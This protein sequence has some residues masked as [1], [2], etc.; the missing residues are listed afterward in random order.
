M[1]FHGLDPFVTETFSFTDT[2]HDGKC[3]AAFHPFSNKVDHNIISRTDRGGN[4]RRSVLNQYLGISKPYVRTMR[5]SRN[6]YQVGKIFRLGI[7]QHLHGKVCTKLRDPEASQPAAADI[8]RADPQSLRSRKQGHDISL[9]QRNCSCTDAGQILQHTDHGR[10]I[11][12]K[13]IKLQ[14]ISVNGMVI[15][16]CGDDIT[17]HIIGRVLHRCKFLNL[18]THRQ[19]DDTSRM[20]ASGTA[21]TGTTLHDT[22]DLTVTLVLPPF[23]IIVL[24]ITKCGFFRKGTNGSRLKGLP[25][26]E[27]NLC[28]PVGIGLIFTGKVQ[29]DIRLLITFKTKEC[30]KRNIKAF[31]VH[32]GTA[33]RTDLIRHITSCHTR[34][35][36]HLRG[37]KITVFTV[38]IRTE[39]MR[40]QRVYLRDTGHGRCQRRTYRT[41]GANQIT[42]LIGFPYQFLC[43]DIHYRITIGNNGV[44]LPVQTILHDLRKRIS[45]HFVGFCKTDILK[46]LL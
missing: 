13:Y 15:K 44:Q 11:V 5:K 46:I 26:S 21:D 31:L 12:S 29:V 16:M 28:I 40:R 36:F 23:L 1:V 7:D 17:V 4:G 39:I 42:V 34:V 32:P 3:Q 38:R 41:S 24:H 35:F 27:D 25:F 33:F 8:L 19:Y 37:I 22:V 10:I 6:T 45:V 14:K 43:N 9:V 2:L 30:L 18:L 20:L